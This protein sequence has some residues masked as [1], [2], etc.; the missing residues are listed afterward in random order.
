VALLSRSLYRSLAAAF[1]GLEDRR[2]HFNHPYP[3]SKGYS[4]HH[5]PACGLIERGVELLCAH[6]AHIGAFVRRILRDPQLRGE[7][8]A[9]VRL[10]AWVEVQFSKDLGLVRDPSEQFARAARLLRDLV[11]ERFVEAQ[12]ADEIESLWEETPLLFP[13]D[14]AMAACVQ[15]FTNAYSSLVRAF[16]GWRDANPERRPAM[17]AW[18]EVDNG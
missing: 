3:R 10:Y 2:L 18:A 9:A 8:K 15:E 4:P 7:G 5:C 14:G 11:P 13:L 16:D 1:D 6:R 17:F 12:W